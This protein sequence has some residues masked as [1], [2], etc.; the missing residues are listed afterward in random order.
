VSRAMITTNQNFHSSVNIAFDLTDNGKVRSFVPTASACSLIEKLFIGI[1]PGSTSRAKVLIG[2]YGRGKSHIVLMTLALLSKKESG[3]FDEYLSSSKTILPEFTRYAT[4]FINSEKP[5]LPVII[6]GNTS[7]LTQAFLQA[8]LSTLR[9][10]GL[11]DLMPQ[12]N[13]QGAINTIEMWRKSYP[14]TYK[15]FEDSTGRTAGEFIGALRSFDMKAYNEFLEK[16]PELTSGGTFDNLSG[17]NVVSVYEETV[18]RLCEFGYHGIYIVYDEFSKYL[19]TSISDAPVSDVKLLQ[20]LAEKC[21]RSG[22]KQ[23]H[24]LL[25]CHKDIANYIDGKLSKE[26]VDGWRGVSGRFEYIEIRN[27]FDQSYELIKSTIVKDRDRWRSF[28]KK[29]SKVLQSLKSASVASN[30]IGTSSL[31]LVIEGC[32]PLHPVTT[33]LLPR[34]SERVAQNERT[35][36]TYLTSS[37]KGSLS[38]TYSM[39]DG[40]DLVFVTPDNLFDY[41]EPLF[42]KEA[43]T[44][45]IHA[46]YGLTRRILARFDDSS[47]EAKIIKVLMLIY[48]VAQ[49]EC[50]APTKEQ[51]ISTFSSVLSWTPEDVNCAIE[52]LIREEAVVYLRKSNGY[53]KLK[54]SSGVDI[55]SKIDREIRIYTGKYTVPAI[56]NE[57][58]SSK[59]VYP[60]QYNDSKEIVRYFQ[61]SYIDSNKYWDIQEHG[62]SRDSGADGHVL[63]VLPYDNEDLKDIKESIVTLS[64]AHPENVFILPKKVREINDVAYRYKAVTSL[65]EQTK[66]DTLLYDEYEVFLEDYSEVI[67]K[68]NSNYFQPEQRSARYYQNGREIRIHRRAHLS[69]LLSNICDAAYPNT[70]IIN[71][72]AINKNELSP[73]AVRSRT[74]ILAGLCS[75][76]MQPNLGLLGNG[77]ECSIM[78]SVFSVTGIIEE[79]E[80]FPKVNFAPG[81]PSIAYV[82]EVIRNFIFSE[83]ENRSLQDLYDIIT[84]TE[85][86]I[87]LKKGLVIL[88]ITTVLREEWSNLLLLKG[89]LEQRL[90]AGVLNDIDCYPGR[91]SIKPI[92]WTKER[93]EFVRR[94]LSIFSDHLPYGYN[95]NDS[96]QAVDAMSRWYFTLPR[97]S[98]TAVQVYNGAFNTES[99]TSL[100]PSYLGLFK[101]LKRPEINPRAFLFE[102]LPKLFGE[103]VSYNELVVLIEEA[104][105]L[106]DDYVKSTTTTLS[107]DLRLLFDSKAHSD[108][109]LNSVINKWLRSLGK[110]LTRQVF[111]GTSNRIMNALKSFNGDEETSLMRLFKAVTSLRIEDWDERTV[112]LFISEMR[113][114]KSDIENS[115]NCNTQPDGKASIKITYLND[116]GETEERA[117]KPAEYSPRAKLLKNEIENAVREMG[118]SID[119]SEKRQVLFDVL[120]E[121]C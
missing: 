6:P 23:M 43:Y 83:E 101:I 84:G 13:I 104:K 105:N 36:F 5:F 9:S 21:N 41:F 37:E 91:Y 79:L 29:Y 94:I 10:E 32:Y 59:A 90:T 119:D 11:E 68:Y 65:Q 107:Y 53:L 111:S 71:N 92:E 76:T 26:R 45:E 86:G 50:L 55:E 81:D 60:A 3:L 19:E 33:F 67:S 112:Q 51:I 88:F 110:E 16:Y 87:G 61:C 117:F 120:K 113:K 34:I 22:D 115:F 62:L 63:A 74:K 114:V 44:S 35:L 85:K 77:Q 89:K 25:I 93:A 72:E 98:K 20:D 52:R 28:S 95:Q 102:E 118:Q 108:A 1:S 15:R 96:T 121:L 97:F 47:L 54:E 40:S 17:L 116:I 80:T 69:S 48:T 46:L 18:A 106:M 64:S 24:I 70:P 73:T 14:D 56:L 42:R 100:P 7:N 78:R 57:T 8:L 27:G 66:D 103:D 30:L 109:T 49:F 2:A 4:E 31:D 75:S 99:Y 38:E 58:V 82:F 12:T 39:F